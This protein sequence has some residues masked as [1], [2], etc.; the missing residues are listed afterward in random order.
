M[1]KLSKKMMISLLTFALVFIALGVSTFAWFTLADSAELTNIEIN[2][3]GGGGLEMALTKKDGTLTDY[4]TNLSSADILGVLG[5]IKLS[6]ITSTDGVTFKNFEEEAVTFNKDADAV[7]SFI[8]LTFNFNARVE[9]VSNPS[10]VA[11]Y[12]VNK[13]SPTYSAN[14]ATQG[15][16]VT[17]EGV[18]AKASHTFTTNEGEVKPTDSAKTYYAK[19]AILVS[20]KDSN[21]TKAKLFDF[22]AAE[23]RNYGDGFSDD[24][25][26]LKGA[27]SFQYNENGVN[28]GAA[29]TRDESKVEEV[30]VLSTFRE[31][32]IAD[33]DN[34]K[35]CI[36]TNDGEG[37]YIGSVTVR[38]WV[39]GFDYDCF[40]LIYSDT[41]LT[42]F[43]FKLGY[44]LA[45]AQ[46]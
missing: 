7:N 30:S 12:L 23:N 36:L 41:I 40:N 42:Q 2:V 18:T 45:A 11:I 38:I 29:P 3:S 31:G 43:E 9:G 5:D 22:N 1:K 17:S 15:T 6:D 14:L 8:E 35:V 21:Q 39:E 24:T 4:K 46:E 34:S 20:F 32:S 26:E 13:Q 16:F 44:K 33:N 10:E 28:P 25:A 27:A 19:D 37:N